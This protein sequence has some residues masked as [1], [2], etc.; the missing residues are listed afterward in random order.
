MPK[1]VIESKVSPGKP[2]EPLN[3]DQFLQS[4]AETPLAQ[5]SNNK[6]GGKGRIIF[7]LDAT[8]S[9]QATWD[10]AS[11]LQAQMFE[12]TAA[13]GS[14]DVQLV[15]YRAHRECRASP[16]LSSSAALLRMMEKI[17]CVAGRT[18]VE[19]VL[20]HG[21]AESKSGQVQALIF[22]GDCF[23]ENL[24][25]VAELAGQLK[26]LGLPLFI[27]QEGYDPTATYAF[28]QLC[29]LSGGAHCRFDTHSAAQLGQ[30]LSAVAVYASGGTAALK[31][32]SGHGSKQAK[33]L[34]E[35]LGR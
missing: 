10:Q 34:L 8:A 28:G 24:D 1:K 32:L 25:T 12:S 14:L 5:P 20:S 26:I 3:V 31:R 2:S 7:A 18:Q 35:Q 29:A 27:F 4:V 19:R 6:D 16:W 17:H 9:R 15:Y 30:L 22:V 21:I 13:L 11:H 23:E 33:L